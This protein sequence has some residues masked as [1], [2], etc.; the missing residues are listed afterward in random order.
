MKNLY[1]DKLGKNGKLTSEEWDCYFKLQLCLFCGLLEHKITDCPSAKN[2]S[3]GKA[4]STVPAHAKL[5][6]E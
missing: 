2:F 3:K 4:S 5:A 6:K 1:A